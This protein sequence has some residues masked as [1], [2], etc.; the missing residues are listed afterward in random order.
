M[1]LA[2]SPP[3]P[4]RLFTL[5]ATQS[6]ALV[7]LSPDFGAWLS[8][9][10]TSPLGKTVGQRGWSSPV[11]KAVTA[12]PCAACGFAPS[13][14]RTTRA[15]LTVGISVGFGGGRVGFVPLLAA[16]SSAADSG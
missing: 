16:R 10:R 3:A 7:D 4:A 9:T 6:V 11:A 5:S 8:A 13:L 15:M 12:R 14:Q 1:R 2:L